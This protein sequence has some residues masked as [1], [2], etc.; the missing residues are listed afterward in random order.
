MK[1]KFLALFVTLVMVSTALSACGGPKEKKEA[2]NSAAQNKTEMSSTDNKAADAATDN[3]AA[4]NSDAADNADAADTAESVNADDLMTQLK[5]RFT[6]GYC[7]VGDDDS[8]LYWAVDDSVTSGMFLIVSPDK[9]QS[10]SLVGMIEEVDDEWLKIT[11]E[12]TGNE[13]TIKVQQIDDNKIQLTKDD[14]SFAILQ[15]V[16]ADQVID[17]MFEI[18]G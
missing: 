3:S 4:D 6:I 15:S 18:A 10:I 8:E 1:K 12:Q 5:E 16:P 17:K 2:D 11:D 7:G 14:G 9:T 13:V